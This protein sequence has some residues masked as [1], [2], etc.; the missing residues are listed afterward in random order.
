MFRTA[1]TRSHRANTMETFPCSNLDSFHECSFSSLDRQFLVLRRSCCHDHLLQKAGCDP[2][3]PKTSLSECCCCL[4]PCDPG[5]TGPQSL[6][7]M[8]RTFNVSHD[9]VQRH[10]GTCTIMKQFLL[11]LWPLLMMDLGTVSGQSVCVKSSEPWILKTATQCV[12]RTQ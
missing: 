3:C 8:T 10:A 4:W 7:E 1:L 2:S 12:L 6:C 5:P 11:P 9:S